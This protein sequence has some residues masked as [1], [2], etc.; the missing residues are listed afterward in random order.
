MTDQLS[1]LEVERPT[2][3]G[4]VLRMEYHAE[5]MRPGQLLEAEKCCGCGQAADGCRT[6]SPLGTDVTKPR[7]GD[8]T[9]V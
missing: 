4:D 1:G 9:F 8:V 7:R 3:Q 6:L 2:R 5:S